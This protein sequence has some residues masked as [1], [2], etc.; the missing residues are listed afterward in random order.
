MCQVGTDRPSKSSTQHSRLVS[1]R[2]C[3]AN[4]RL[5]L[6]V[7]HMQALPAYVMGMQQT[8][9]FARLHQCLGR[10]H[11]QNAA[12]DGCRP[13]LYWHQ[14]GRHGTFAPFEACCIQASTLTCTQRCSGIA[15][16]TGQLSSDKLSASTTDWGMRPAHET[17]VRLWPK[18]GHHALLTS[19]SQG[20]S[21]NKCTTCGAGAPDRAEHNPKTSS[22]EPPAHH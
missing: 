5:T 22:E 15:R 12:A 14:S 7:S 13:A 6:H 21:C 19:T 11:K 18:L 3:I 16:I 10:N 9:L 8:D 4:L 20:I 2:L 17:Y 1:W